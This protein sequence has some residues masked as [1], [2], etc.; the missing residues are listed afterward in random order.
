MLVLRKKKEADEALRATEERLREQARQERARENAERLQNMQEQWSRQP[1]PTEAK[2]SGGPAF[3]DIDIGDEDEGI[4]PDDDEEALAPAPGAEEAEDAG[5]GAWAWSRR[6][7][8][9]PSPRSGPGQ[10]APS[11]QARGWRGARRPIS[12]ERAALRTPPGLRAR[13]RTKG[14]R[15]GHA[16]GRRQSW[17]KTTRSRPG[18][19]S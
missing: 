16:R 12:L 4:V 19:I 13:R 9:K 5:A 17:R 7:R 14:G 11:G 8:K 10:S 15:C 1:K 6:T 18:E 2:E 3:P